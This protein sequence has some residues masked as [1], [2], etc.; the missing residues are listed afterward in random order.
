MANI[1]DKIMSI[2]QYTHAIPTVK[3]HLF[4]VS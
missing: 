3:Q 4:L 1:N 2:T